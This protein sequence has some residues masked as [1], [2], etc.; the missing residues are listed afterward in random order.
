MWDLIVSVS[1]HCLSFYFSLHSHQRGLDMASLRFPQ[2]LTYDVFCRVN[3]GYKTHFPLK[4]KW[5]PWKRINSGQ[6]IFKYVFSKL[7]Q[8]KRLLKY[9]TYMEN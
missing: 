4:T 7:F 6:L 3:K 5:L 8:S 2:I 1:D 9:D